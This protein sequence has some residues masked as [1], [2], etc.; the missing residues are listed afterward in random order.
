MDESPAWEA[1]TDEHGQVIDP[2][3]PDFL[4][5]DSESLRR[6]YMC[7]AVAERMTEKPAAD[8]ETRLLATTIFTSDIDT[9]P[10]D[11]ADLAEGRIPHP[12]GGQHSFDTNQ[13]RN[14]LGRWVDM[15]DV[16][17]PVRARANIPELK[18]P[19]TPVTVH[20]TLEQIRDAGLDDWPKPGAK[21]KELL[22]D[23]KDTFALYGPEEP[24]LDPKFPE[25]G[26]DRKAQQESLI[27]AELKDKRRPT[28]HD[29]HVLF[30]AGGPASGKSTVLRR[31]RED[32]APPEQTTVHVDVDDIKAKM[33]EHGMTEYDQMRNADPPDRYA[34]MAVHKEAGDIATR[35]VAAAMERGLNVIIDGTGDSDPGLYSQQLK[36]MKAAGYTVDA[37]YVDRSTAE[38]VVL[39]VERAERSGRF[40]PIPVVRDQH[41]K[42]SINYRDEISKLDFLNSLTVYDS[43]GPIAV[44]REDGS[45]EEVRPERYA[46]FMAKADEKTPKG[47]DRLENP[48]AEAD[49]SAPAVPPE[50]WIPEMPHDSSEFLARRNGPWP[51]QQP[52][53]T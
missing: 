45:I 11:E 42:V 46:E 52:S 15:P 23:A 39:S 22:G 30:M 35:M 16:S 36:D 7:V 13:W 4:V 32:F 6:W 3:I 19:G 24:D 51:R 10:P 2:S 5:Y 28:D 34:A 48:L 43:Q 17:E 26:S 33:A 9:G 53:D 44:M 47:L 29:P 41:R 20:T 37:L 1:V 38:S 40:V 18:S 8:P 31:N 27:A 50:N 12:P 49:M 25:Y 21:A 14:R